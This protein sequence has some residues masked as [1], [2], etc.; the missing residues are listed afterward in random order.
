MNSRRRAPTLPAIA[1]SGSSDRVAG[2]F[3][4]WMGPASLRLAGRCSLQ[5]RTLWIAC[6]ASRQ[7]LPPSSSPGVSGMPGFDAV[8]NRRRRRPFSDGRADRGQHQASNHRTGIPLLLFMGIALYTIDGT[9]RS[10][11]SDRWTMLHGDRPGQ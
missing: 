5:R 2:W 3:S 7:P 4:F 11:E 10:S 6:S 9:A 8:S 1:G